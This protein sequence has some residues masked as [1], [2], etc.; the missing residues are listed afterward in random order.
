[1]LLNVVNTKYSTPC[2][3]WIM[4]HESLPKMEGQSGPP[5]QSITREVGQQIFFVATN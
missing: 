2:T 3:T 5:L 1:M 4:I